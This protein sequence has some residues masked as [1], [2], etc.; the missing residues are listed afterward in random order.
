MSQKYG[1]EGKKLALKQAFLATV[2]VTALIGP[3][4][5]EVIYGLVGGVGQTPVD[6][7]ISFDSATPGTIISNSAISGTGGSPIVGI[8]FRPANGA[9]YGL[10]L[11]SQL[12]TI[13]L[14]SGSASPIG[15][16]SGAFTTAAGAGG[17][18]FDFNPTVDAIR[19][20][21]TNSQN[22]RINPTT[23]VVTTD[24]NLAYAAGSSLAGTTPG[25][26]AVAYTNSV[27]GATTTTLFDYDARNSQLT[28]QNPANAG[29]LNPVAPIT[30][31]SSTFNGFDISGATGTAYL[32][33]S[34]TLFSLNLATG[35]ATGIGGTGFVS[36]RDLS[37]Q[38]SGPG[39]GPGPGPNPV[40][41]PATLAVLGAGLLGLAGLR[42]RRA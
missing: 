1:T 25:V 40:P 41:E 42:R 32:V 11:N 21:N 23:G 15:S 33:N 17:F 37:V 34:T 8:D 16:P 36:L 29:T 35:V 10:G 24:P 6:R 12:Y 20:V 28:T 4:N 26:T 38:I 31:S 39:P 3:A 14:G 13:D 22:L 7:L 30:G 5:A 9:L 18:G 19:V 27:A 2:A